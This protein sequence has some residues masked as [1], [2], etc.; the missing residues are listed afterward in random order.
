MRNAMVEAQDLRQPQDLDKQLMQES[1]LSKDVGLAMVEL[2][3]VFTSGIPRVFIPDQQV[4]S[5]SSQGLLS[6]TVT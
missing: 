5:V 1:G 6:S 3:Q 4:D 2:L